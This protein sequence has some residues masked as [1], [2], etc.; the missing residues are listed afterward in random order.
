M[1]HIYP[2]PNGWMI[3]G[4]AEFSESGSDIVCAGVSA[5]IQTMSHAL[6]DLV[7]ATESR[8]KD[9]Y[10]ITYPHGWET[11]DEANQV[12]QI[13][14]YFMWG[15]RKIAEEFPENVTIHKQLPF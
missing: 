2:T 11:H 6:S 8:D 3:T 13:E 1:I 4:H 12:L 14:H 10:H 15:V 7:D 9:A 5:L